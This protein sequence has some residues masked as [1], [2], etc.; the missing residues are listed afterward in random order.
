MLIQHSV[1]IRQPLETVEAYLT[2]ITNNHIWQE[3]V[4]ESEKLSNGVTGKGTK[5]YE[6][7]NIMNFSIRS[8]WEVTDYI[9]GRT[10]S[11]AST[12]S[13][14]PYEGTFD[15]EKVEESTKVTFTFSIRNSGINALF[16]PFIKSIFSPRLRSNLERL[17]DILEKK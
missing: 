15:L 14:A 4:L 6:V 7:R 17:V 10:F 11:F 5:A 1:I 9:P 13:V 12:S 3:D 2:D 8:E 16:D